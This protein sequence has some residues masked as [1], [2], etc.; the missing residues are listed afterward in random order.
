[1]AAF[2]NLGVCPSF[3][4]GLE[5][6]GWDIPT[7]IQQECIPL[8]LGGGDVLAAAETGSGK[9]AA[10]ALPV[11]QNVHETLVR[12]KKAN[13][14]SSASS[15]A[16]AASSS[17]RNQNEQKKKKTSTGQPPHQNENQLID[18]QQNNSR[19]QLS[20]EDRDPML[21]V[22]SDGLVC[23]SR[24]ERNWSGC[25]ATLGVHSHGTFYY[26]VTVR[27]EGLCRV[28]WSC[29][30]AAKLEL[31]TCNLG[32]GYGGTAK[33]SNGKRFEDYGEKYGKG[34]VIGCGIEFGGADARPC[35]WYT[36][37]GKFLGKAFE[38][39]KK[40]AGQV[41][42]PALCMKNAELGCN[43]G[44]NLKLKPMK[45]APKTSTPIAVASS[46]Q[47][48][49]AN[50]LDLSSQ[51]GNNANG[52]AKMKTPLGLILEP[53]RDLAEQTARVVGELCSSLAH[54]TLSCVCCV[55]GI[56]PKDQL[57][58]LQNGC[59]VV[60][61]TP[62]RVLDF[63]ESGKL[64]LSKVKFYVLDE[65]DRLVDDKFTREIV[66][67]LFKR[68]PKQ[69]LAGED[70][71]QCLMFSATLHSESIK[72][73]A[74]VICQNPIWVDLK[75]RD[76]V[77]ETVHHVQYQ[78]DPTEDRSWLQKSPKVY[79]DQV[80]ACDKDCAALSAN[81][82]G[83][84]CMSE[85]VKLLK[86][87]VLQRII[88]AFQMDQCLIFCRT[89]FDCDQLERF[90]NELGGGQAF[91][92]KVEKG[93]ENPYSC[94]VL[95][96]ARSMH[97]RRAALSAF[98]DG[99]V[100][101][102]ICT[103]VAARGIDIKELPYVINMCLPDLTQVEDYIHRV[104][105]VGRADTMGLA[106]SIVSKA[107]ERVWYCTKKGYKPWLEPNKS[108]TKLIG[109]GGHTKWYSEQEILKAIEKRLH[110]KVIHLNEDMSLPGS[111]SRTEYGSKE[112][113]K[114]SQDVLMRVEK[115]KPTVEVLS[116]LEVLAQRS[117][118]NFRTRWIK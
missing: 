71:L 88:D 38:V 90:L 7:P 12:L 81:S 102:L 15:S 66:M 76:A 89:N 17:S 10:F 2:G 82:K 54:P 68:L 40:L 96:G 108:N 61:G 33:K 70:R 44:G 67:K 26:E 100:R 65:A 58:Q 45:N 55:G 97:E 30:T 63:V 49:D 5:Q 31:G 50:A 29:T 104:G 114:T 93:L 25:R 16:S 118:L 60:V 94:V 11:L 56:N 92:G 34:D 73:I 27:D 86:P 75:G 8:V 52:G 22:S 109:E 85:A 41:F 19:C 98:K 95:A 9:T 47:S 77:P 101:F 87:R 80:H 117:F 13:A 110:Q 39:P 43:F 1:M 32:F 37:N 46:S 107:S 69:G 53:T 14:S 64:I 18:Q 105:R 72:D 113:D 106:I 62:A 36:K 74:K 24:G 21:A 111:I 48:A 103:D 115:L 83:K 99:D 28:G 23:Q 3:I 79:T 20:T 78:V 57:K 59:D 6:Q 51:G 42:Y 84:D 112:K 91:R 4:T 35:I 116:E